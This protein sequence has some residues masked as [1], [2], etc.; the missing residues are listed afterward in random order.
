[1]TSNFSRGQLLTAAELNVALPIVNVMMSPFNAVGDGVADDTAALNAA[2]AFGSNNTIGIY[3]PAGRYRITTPLFATPQGS[4]MKSCYVFG[5]GRGYASANGQ[6][7]ID[8]TALTNVPAIIIQRGRGCYLGHFLIL[9]GNVAP[10]NLTVPNMTYGAA[11]VTGGLRDSRYSPYCG[12]SI[13]GGVGSV[14]R[15]RRH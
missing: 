8:A 14:R 10:L 15:L 6:T 9:G 5:A 1:M 13:D 2:F 7:V 11:W 12:I 4:N 3:I